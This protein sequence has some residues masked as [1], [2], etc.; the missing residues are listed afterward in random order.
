MRRKILLMLFA[1]GFATGAVF[2]Y[3]SISTFKKDKL[4]YIFETNNSIINNISEQFKKELKL[5]TSATKNLVSKLKTDGSFGNPAETFIN[6]DSPVD[7]L[8]V[9]KLT[10]NR[11]LQLFTG[12][13]KVEI[14][15][16]NYSLDPIKGKVVAQI[17]KKEKGLFIRGNIVVIAELSKIEG[18]NFV[19]VYYFN[20]DAL[21]TFFNEEKS[22]SSLMITS[23]GQ[24]VKAD[25][26]LTPDYIENNFMSFFQESKLLNSATSKIQSNDKKDWLLTSITAGFE[27]YYF[28]SL[29][30]EAKAMSALNSLVTNSILIFILMLFVIIIIGVVMSTYLTSR[31]SLLSAATKKVIEGDL[32]TVVE[33]RGNDE[34]TELTTNFN[35]MTSEIVRLMSE[36]A[37]KARMESELKTAKV[38]QETLFPKAETNFKDLHIKG[39]Y[40]SAS[41]CGGDWWHYSEDKDKI[42]LWIADATGHGASAALLTSAAKSAVSLIET[43]NVPPAQSMALLNK[44]ICSVSKE[45]MMMTCFLA[46]FNKSTKKLT[47]VNASHEAPILL[48]FVDQL[49][50]KDLIHLNE[51]SSNRLGQSPDSTYSESEIQLVPGD[52]ML[53]YTDGIPDIQNISGEPL[54]ERGFIKQLLSSV[55]AH[56]MFPEFVDHFTNS[57]VDYRQN[58]ELVDDVTYCFT[59]VN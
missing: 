12:L 48:K 50:K 57:L 35:H 10:P 9:Y 32:K 16:A 31:L 18:E 17:T 58:T 51:N 49:K 45:N 37:H 1:V 27:N 14:D 36:T 40:I 56:L 28:V 7:K 53:F 22:F 29:V 5:S 41:E 6:A 24:I 39:H 11:E 38:V 59:E 44:A 54:Q 20:S 46:A 33:P 47:Y 30:D 15:K 25:E 34:I 42:Y 21:Q 23:D 55:N 2:L 4:A 13:S 19:L 26:T 43:M 52:R 8:E 3:T